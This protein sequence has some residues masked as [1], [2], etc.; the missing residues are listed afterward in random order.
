MSWSPWEHSDSPLAGA[1]LSGTAP[2]EAGAAALANPPGR[3]QLAYRVGTYDTFVPQMID[4]LVMN[5]S[6]DSASARAGED[7]DGEPD[8]QSRYVRFNLDK[9]DNWLIALARSWASVADVLTFYQERLIQEGYL[10]TAVEPRSVYELVHMVGYQPTPG[11][12]GHTDL[13]IHVTDVKGLPRE[14]ELPRR[15]VVR[16]VPPPGALPQVF[17]TVD[18]LAARASW[19]LLTP[20]PRG[21]KVAPEVLAGATSLRLAGART[22]L[23]VGD[24]LLVVGT[25]RDGGAASSADAADAAPTPRP[26]R[27]VRRLTAMEPVTEPAPATDVQWSGPL[28]LDLA[29]FGRRSATDPGFDRAAAALASEEVQATAVFALRRQVGLFGRSA[30]P[31]ADLPPEVKRDAQE[32]T[33]GVVVD[34]GKG[35]KSRNRGLPVEARVVSLAGDEGHLYAGTLAHGVFDS[36]DGGETWEAARRGLPQLDVPV[37]IVDA[38]GVVWTGG[39]GGSVAR[40]TDQGALWEDASGRLTPPRR[41]PWWKRW[42]PLKKPVGGALPGAAIHALAAVPTGSATGGA[43]AILA[44]TGAGV[45]RTIDGG[46][47]WLAANRGLPGTDGA[48]GATDLAVRGLTPG[49]R[50]DEVWAATLRGVY[51]SRDG[52]Q[53]W[54]PKNRGLP[55]PDPFTGFSSTRADAVAVIADRRRAGQRLLAAT[56]AGLYLSDDGGEHWQP[57]PIDP[58]PLDG[59][60]GSEA[61]PVTSLQVVEDALTLDRRVYAATRESLWVSRDDG[62]SW[63]RIELTAGP[64]L[65]VAA[66]PGGVV[67]AGASGGPEVL[68]ALPYAGFADEW[69]R[70]YLRDGHIDLE[71]RIDGITPGTW[72]VLL[73]GGTDDPTAAGVYQI[74]RVTQRRRQDF[75]LDAIVTRL[76]VEPDGRFADFDLRDTRVYLDSRVL[77]LEPLRVVDHDLAVDVLGVSLKALPPLRRV[78]VTGE[79]PAERLR[80]TL[81]L[82]TR[83]EELEKALAILESFP[84]DLLLLLRLWSL[85]DRDPAVTGEPNNVVSLRVGEVLGFLRILVEVG[86]VLTRAPAASTGG[87]GIARAAA[88]LAPAAL[89]SPVSAS[90]SIQAEA[91]RLQ[92]A[93]SALSSLPDSMGQVL[94]DALGLALHAG[95]GQRSGAGLAQAPVAAATVDRAAGARHAA[96][97]GEGVEA[98]LTPK[99]PGDRLYMEIEAP[100]RTVGRV[101]TAAELGASL[102]ARVA[103]ERMPSRLAVALPAQAGEESTGGP[104][105]V[106][107]ASLRIF[108]NVVSAVE[109]S[110]VAG[111]VLGDGDATQANQVFRLAQ[112]PAFRLGG[113]LPAPGVDVPVSAADAATFAST[114]E[115]RVRGQLWHRAEHLEGAT[116]EARVYRLDVDQGGIG[117]LVFGSGEQGA[118]LPSGTDNVRAT[119]STG[120]S[121]RS[122]P[123]GGIALPQN[124]PLGLD[125]VAN[126]LP[127]TPGARA[128]SPEVAR[129]R[130]PRSVRTLGRV[131]SLR[132][133]ADFA[134][135]FPGVV[136]ASSWAVRSAADSAGGTASGGGRPAVQLTVAVEGGAAASSGTLD[137]LRAA[138]EARRSAGVP[139]YVQDY[140][141]VRLRAIAKLLIDPDLPWRIVEETVERR[142]RE[143]FGFARADFGGAVSAAALVRQIQLVEGVQAVDLD[144]LS[145]RDASRRQADGDSSRGDSPSRDTPS[146]DTPRQCR[147]RPPAWEGGILRPAELVLLTDVVLSQFGQP[148]GVPAGLPA[149]VGGGEA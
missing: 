26:L 94:A 55:G 54:Q 74:Q 68:A 21:R 6:A 124:R 22:G 60:L 2:R 111:E 121:T 46:R 135:D 73:P 110:T 9:E 43:Q 131:V 56:D 118:R 8:I 80:L 102:G 7:A 35:W 91:L 14:I 40:S 129:Q 45:Y 92:T 108:G 142:L 117:S 88:G 81:E 95:G 71:G 87:V 83:L 144:E 66:G 99:A 64:I 115:V 63:Q 101:T 137:D 97:V 105:R 18:P 76:E 90:G 4:R 16:S 78:I 32:I 39:A 127:S 103:D 17:E 145:W 53:R 123:E 140:R 58:G 112:P 51:V 24:P 37:L 114:V 28:S 104:P 72:A 84:E 139:L 48:N 62:A 132:D 33:G 141:P 148:R 133:Y 70:F 147:A 13:A 20:D 59:A 82:G 61:Q 128:E 19:N 15:L 136:K 27:C 65:A 98:R 106:D 50:R 36:T 130:A 143:R 89:A 134:L 41:Q 11:I 93:A 109:G 12:A 96:V 47:T 23:A 34:D 57:Q 44:G 31:W 77:A 49:A 120:M 100:V 125:S 52:G 122:V 149:G 25:V 116:A 138:I 10:P 75:G 86:D 5:L 85:G 30:P 42:W 113:G 38:Q 1:S 146:R 69:P 119:Y 29:R 3:R 79:L 126:P 107:A 67:G